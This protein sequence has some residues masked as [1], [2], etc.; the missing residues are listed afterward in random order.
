MKVKIK[1]YVI[2][3]DKY[4]FTLSTEFTTEKGN[5]Y[6][7]PQGYWP[8]L[9]QLIERLFYLDLADSDAKTLQEML[10]TIQTTKDLIKAAG[11][12]RQ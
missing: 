7:R 10:D 6:L 1:N 3:A 12:T 4:Q 8:R 11:L 5:V 9:E 2:T